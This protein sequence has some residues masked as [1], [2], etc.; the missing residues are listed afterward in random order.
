MMLYEGEEEAQ[1][2]RIHAQLY[3]PPKGMKRRSSRG[4]SLSAAEDIL[5]QV[6]LE[7]RKLGI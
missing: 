3:M 7:G 4:V 1:I 5:Q 2:A 6:A